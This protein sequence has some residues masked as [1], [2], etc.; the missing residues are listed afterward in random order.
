VSTASAQ[1]TEFDVPPTDPIDLFRAWFDGAKQ[2]GVREPGALALA[3]ADA[4]GRPSNR[5]VQIIDVTGTDLVFTS[6]AGSRKG[7]DLAATG[8]ASGVLYWRETSRQVVLTG[9][10]HRMPDAESDALWDARP[11]GTHPMSPRTRARRSTTR[12]HCAP[13]PSTSPRAELRCRAPK[14]GQATC[15]HPT[16]WSSGRAT[17]TDCTAGCA[18]TGPAAAGPPD[19]SSP[20]PTP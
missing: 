7:R 8:R 2:D 4:R 17:R 16:R 1:R 19:G 5:I 15:S 10:V 14:A 18:T 12:R 3:T 9:P 6:H 13:T 20:D 11:I